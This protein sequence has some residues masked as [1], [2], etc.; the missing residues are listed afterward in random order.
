MFYTLA[1]EYKIGFS[2][3]RGWALLAS[4]K[5]R[6]FQKEIFCANGFQMLFLQK[7]QEWYR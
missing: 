4:T 6:V 2:G 5:Q 1:E 7:C 3:G